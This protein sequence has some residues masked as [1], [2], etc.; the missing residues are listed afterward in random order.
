MM[1]KM[2]GISQI[3]T[4][5]Q[6]C[7]SGSRNIPSPSHLNP[8]DLLSGLDLKSYKKRLVLKT[9]RKYHCMLEYCIEWILY[10]YGHN[11]S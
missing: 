6:L 9:R 3:S 10:V 5:A 7:R 1:A 4:G 8:K 11:A 2:F